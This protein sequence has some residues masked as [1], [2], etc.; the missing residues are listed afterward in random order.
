LANRWQ[1]ATRRPGASGEGWFVVRIERFAVGSI[2]CQIVPDGVAM[3]EP[4]GFAVGV[5]VGQITAAL[6]ARAQDT[7]QF[8]FPY[9]CLLIRAGGRIALVD[10]GMGAEGAPHSGEPAGRLM[11]SLTVGGVTAEQVDLVIISHA[12]PDH[13]GGLTVPAGSRRVP[14]FTRARHYF[15]RPSGTS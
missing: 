4:G 11:D 12:H 7:G 1:A 6:T 13:I 14:V 3:Y 5:P 8:A 15:G 2:Q 9:N 10:T